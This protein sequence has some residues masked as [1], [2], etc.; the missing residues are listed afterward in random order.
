M[1]Y[2]CYNKWH[3]KN[4]HDNKTID[5]NAI[6]QRIVTE[7]CECKSS[8][9]CYPRPILLYEIFSLFLKHLV[10]YSSNPKHSLMSNLV[11]D[12][13]KEN[14]EMVIKDGNIFYFFY[15]LQSMTILR[16][17]LTFITAIYFHYSFIFLPSRFI[18]CGR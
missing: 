13:L 14:R 10:E 15:A 2:I 6:K 11:I 17:F 12:F 4:Y 18:S 1:A 5:T 7:I 16:H 9:K 8:Q 3:Q